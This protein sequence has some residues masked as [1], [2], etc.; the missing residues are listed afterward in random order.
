[1]S[2]ETKVKPL[3]GVHPIYE[4]EWSVYP[5]IVRVLMRDGKVV[6][7]YLPAEQPKPI[8]GKWLD[9]F[10]KTCQ[11]GYPTTKPRVKRLGRWK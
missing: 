9:H 6:N 4:H 5:E 8:L 3:P 10:N 2:E 11:V 1:M 7:Y